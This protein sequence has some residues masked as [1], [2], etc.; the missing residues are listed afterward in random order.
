[1]VQYLLT[2]HGLQNYQIQVTVNVHISL[3]VQ[4]L[5]ASGIKTNVKESTNITFVRRNETVTRRNH[6]QQNP[7]TRTAVQALKRTVGSSIQKIH[8]QIIATSF[9]Q[10]IKQKKLIGNLPRSEFRVVQADKP[11]RQLTRFQ[12]TVRV[13]GQNSQNSLKASM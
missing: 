1:M 5:M 8:S 4:F 10:M 13:R 6:H 2:L 12:R 11:G 3:A 7:L 9:I